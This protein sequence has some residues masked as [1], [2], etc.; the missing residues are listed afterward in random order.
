MKVA[1]KSNKDTNKCISILW[2]NKKKFQMD[3]EDPKVYMK[4]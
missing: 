3:L 1:I 4:L 2:P